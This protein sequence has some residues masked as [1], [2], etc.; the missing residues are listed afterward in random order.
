MKIHG[1]GNQIRHYLH[2]DDFTDGILLIIKKQIKNQIINFGSL[3][4]YKNKE[5]V[6]KISKYMHVNF[7]KNVK[8]IK[9]RPFNDLRY[10]VSFAKAKSY[11]WK[12]SRKFDENIQYMIQ[13]YKNNQNLFK[14]AK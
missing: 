4:K 14:N 9:D 5:I 11:G 13:W 7:S 6:K 2:I 3:E 10:K 8:F 1:T 12:P